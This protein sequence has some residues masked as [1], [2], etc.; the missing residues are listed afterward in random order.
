[1]R[2]V[3]AG[4]V[5]ALVGAAPARAAAGVNVSSAGTISGTPVVGAKLTVSNGSWSGPPG[6]WTSRVWMRCA[7][8]GTSN[9]ASID[10]ATSTTYT[11]AKVDQGKRLRVKLYAVHGF[12]WDS[13]LSSATGVVGAAATPT[14]TPTRTPTPTPTRPPTRTPTPMPT[15]P[16]D[17]VA[18]ATPT[19]EVTPEPPVEPVVEVT[20]EPV[21]QP[22][23]AEL[24]AP[25]LVPTVPA[26]LK[27]LRPH[28]IVRVAG[29]LTERGAFL[30]RLTVRAPKGARIAVTCAGAHCPRRAVA[31]AASLVHVRAFERALRAGTTLT[32]T[33]SKPGYYTKVTRIVIRRGKVPLRTDG[34]RAPDQKKLI[35]CPSR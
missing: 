20:R 24:A 26:K 1:M 19:P 8:G 16:V 35:R 12:D 2:I 21:V 3:L 33:V 7:D 15:P 32:V 17:P 18:S 11:V 27:L 13:A 30:S 25:V 5:L 34:C 23:P 10:G 31:Q 4:L 28:P 14:P 6:T 22:S 29:R 9:C